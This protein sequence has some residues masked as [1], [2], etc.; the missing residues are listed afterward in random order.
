MN[1]SNFIVNENIQFSLD[2]RISGINSNIALIGEPGCGKTSLIAYN[3]MH[4]LAHSHVIVD[5]KNKLYNKCD[6]LNTI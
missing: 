4:L 5:I 3:M 2:D 1:Q 6:L